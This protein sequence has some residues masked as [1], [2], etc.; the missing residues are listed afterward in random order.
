[1]G[2]HNPLVVGSNPTPR[3]GKPRKTLGGAFQF[4]P[5]L[6]KP[7]LLR[8]CLSALS[9]LLLDRAALRMGA[10]T[11]ASMRGAERI[12]GTARI[13]GAGARS[14]VDVRTGAAG[15]KIRGGACAAGA[16]AT[17]GRFAAL[18]GACASAGGGV[19]LTLTALLPDALTSG[20]ASDL[21]EFSTIGTGL[22]A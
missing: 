21:G 10:A 17:G 5:I 22:G 7:P 9:E 6:F 2:T 13:S 8:D 20:I 4:R 16:N 14:G 15:A 18:T 11:G 3:N 19:G 12:S 1:M